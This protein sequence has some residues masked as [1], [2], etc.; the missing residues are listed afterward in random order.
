MIHKYYYTY[1]IKVV[2]PQSSL[3]GAYYFGKHETDDLN[4]GYF[5]SSRI[6]RNYRKTH[7][8][9][10]LEKTILQY[11]NSREALCAAEHELVEEKRKDPTIQCLNMREGGTGGRWKD[12]VSTEV[13]EER[14]RKSTE[15]FL[16][17]TTPEQRSLNA[18]KAGESRRTPERRKAQSERAI[19]MH[20]ERSEEFK[21]EVYTKAG[22]SRREFNQTD[23][24][25]QR[26]EEIRL[27]N[28]QTNKD[29]SKQWRAEFK[30]LFGCTPESFR[31]FGKLQKSLDLFKKI[32]N[33]ST[34]EQTN[35]INRFMESLSI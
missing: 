32:K 14:V 4:D 20:A 18:R 31:K 6:L 8:I 19:K 9:F 25:K 16:K 15:Y 3:F 17:K 30:E 34:E 26:L 24:G 27:K 1:Q 23:F 35:E 10:G 7:G 22:Q 13:F 33:L 21:A 12:Y 29:V 5:G 2:N 11:Y 28:V